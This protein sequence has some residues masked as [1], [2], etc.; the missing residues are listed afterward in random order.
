MNLV[1]M[2]VDMSSEA[3]CAPCPESAYPYGLRICLNDEQCKAL[4]ILG[5][6][7]TGAKMNVIASAT[8]VM[9]REEGAVDEPKSEI[10]L[11][12]QI[13]D[14][15]LAAPNLMYPNSNMEK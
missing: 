1:S 9:C 3:C 12:L 6:V 8:V 13:T 5:A 14:M 7:G 2:K 11:D 10:Y 4:G 15:A